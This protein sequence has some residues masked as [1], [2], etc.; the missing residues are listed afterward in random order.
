MVQK[1]LVLSASRYDFEDSASH[2]QVRGLSVITA[3]T[4]PSSS[5][6]DVVGSKPTKNTLP[7]DRFS[8]FSDVVLP[9]IADVDLEIDM[10]S[11]KAV[12]LRFSNFVPI[13]S[14]AD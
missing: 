2:R 12:P 7:Y 8:E 10:N 9:A 14:L 6:A 11:M 4:S 1:M 13:S 5:S 3:S